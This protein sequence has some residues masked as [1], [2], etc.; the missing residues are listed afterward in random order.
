V[1]DV[2]VSEEVRRGKADFGGEPSGTW[3]FPDQ[4]YCP[5]GVLAAA[6]LVEMVGRSRK[7]LSEM[8]SR[9]PLY[10][11]IRGSLKFE[12]KEKQVVIKRVEREMR[13]TD[14][15]EMLTVDGWRL[16]FEDG[17]ALVRL[18]GTEPR[19]RYVAEAREEKRAKEIAASISAKIRR[20]L[21]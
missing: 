5:D 16:Q 6:R 15:E 2:F 19:I 10:P 1:G 12:P 9:I 11:T 8:R 4:T 7:A 13:S 21:K 3:I 17:W 14:C 18:S 20:C